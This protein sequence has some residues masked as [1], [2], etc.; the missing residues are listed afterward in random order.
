MGCVY[1]KVIQECGKFHYNSIKMGGYVSLYTRI[2]CN[3]KLVNLNGYG[4]DINKYVM[5]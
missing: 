1:N 2:I 5:E 4:Q 3:D